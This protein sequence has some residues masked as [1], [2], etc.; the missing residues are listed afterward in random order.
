MVIGGTRPISTSNSALGLDDVPATMIARSVSEVALAAIN[1]RKCRGDMQGRPFTRSQEA[2][3]PSR[4]LV[5]E[6]D[7]ARDPNRSACRQE[8][9]HRPGPGADWLGA[10]HRDKV[11]HRRY[12]GGREKNGL[13]DHAVMSAHPSTASV[14]RAQEEA[15][16]VWPTR[17]PERI[18][19]MFT[20]HGN[21]A[22]VDQ[23]IAQQGSVPQS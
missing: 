3:E 15:G 10:A 14:T 13:G 8:A 5:S 4:R 2:Q 11:R 19:K 21:L 17:S 12:R 22:G 7:A 18:C 1:T 6:Y 20:N 9:S 23:R 16:S